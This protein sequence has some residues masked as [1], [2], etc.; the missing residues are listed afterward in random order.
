MPPEQPL[1]EHFCLTEALPRFAGG[2]AE[3]IV[4]A[5]PRGE[6]TPSDM[7][8]GKFLNLLRAAAAA[9]NRLRPM[10]RGSAVG[11]PA[12]HGRGGEDRPSQRL[13]RSGG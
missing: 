5:D 10:R 8:E 6:L 11:P 13:I 4:V 12:R 7:V 3:E 1:I 9:G 2:D